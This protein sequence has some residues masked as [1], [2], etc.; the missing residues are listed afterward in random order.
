MCEERA[1]YV[2][3]LLH[4]NDELRPPHFERVHQHVYRVI[5]LRDVHLP[6]VQQG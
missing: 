4:D 2:D 1:I 5:L 6:Q 3:R